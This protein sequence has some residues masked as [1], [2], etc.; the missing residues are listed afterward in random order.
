MDTNW[1]NSSFRNRFVAAVTR[2]AKRGART[3]WELAKVIAPA[4]I[5][6]TALAHTPLFDAMTRLFAPVMGLFGLRGEAAIV[7]VL[8]NFVNLYAPLGAIASL[9]FTAKEVTTMA[10]MLSFSH[11]LVVETAVTKRLGVSFWGVL[12]FRLGLAAVAGVLMNVI[13]W[14]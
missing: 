9:D 3:S 8:G 4:Y 1:P 5:G 13:P 12:A 2:G 11:G 14:G 7:L 6:V 10:L